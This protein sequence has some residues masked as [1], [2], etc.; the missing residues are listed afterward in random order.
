MLLWYKLIQ[1]GLKFKFQLKFWDAYSCYKVI[2]LNLH[3]W[4]PNE[5]LRKVTFNV[6][7]HEGVHKTNDIQLS[8]K[9]VG[10]CQRCIE[11][12]EYC[13]SLRQKRAYVSFV[14]GITLE[15]T[16]N[17]YMLLAVLRCKVQNT[18]EGKTHKK[19]FSQWYFLHEIP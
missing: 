12:K 2:F 8:K 11:C 13:L 9:Q 3:Y 5:Y 16:Q 14:I 1:R 17:T 4:K 15:I 10:I 6:V 19:Y 7:H 18:F